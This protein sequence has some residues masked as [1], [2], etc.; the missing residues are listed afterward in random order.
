MPIVRTKVERPFN[1]HCLLLTCAQRHL[2]TIKENKEKKEGVWEYDWLGA[3]VLSA[4]SIEAIGNSYGKILIRD[5]KDLIRE[6]LDKKLGASPIWKLTLVAERCGIVPDFNSHPWLTAKKLTE[7]RDLI[8]HAKRE[9]LEHEK[10]CV[11]SDCGLVLNARLL[12][13]VEGMI[14]EEFAT[15]S[16]GAVAEI[17]TALNATLNAEGLYKLATDGHTRSATIID[18]R[19]E[20]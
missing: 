15:K 17:M 19:G 9:P 20:N 18:E 10:D 12:S 13:D 2:K 8:V 3:I 11:E 14:T 7:F 5:W 16:C 1:P 4:L 6:R